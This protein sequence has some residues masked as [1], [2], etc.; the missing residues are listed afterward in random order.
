MRPRFCIVT[1]ALALAPASIEAADAPTVQLALD[2]A[3]DLS[4][5]Y[6]TVIIPANEH[7]FVVIF[8]CGDRQNHHIATKF[9]PID[10]TGP[11]RITTVA[12]A[13]AFPTPDG[14]RFLMRQ[15][16]LTDIPLGRW[17][18]TA[19]V[20]D[21]VVGGVE[22]KVVPP[23][24]ALKLS[25]PI[26]L[27][28]SLSKGTEWTYQFRLLAEPR[29]GLKMKLDEIRNADAQGW[30]ETTLLQRIISLDPE[31]ARREQRRGNGPAESAW[32]AATDRG[33]AVTRQDS[34]D[35][36]QPVDPAQLMVLSPNQQFHRSW[37]W[38][39]KDT[40][41]ELSQKYQMWGPLPL[42]TP[43]GER[44]GYVVLQRI[45]NPDDPTKVATSVE[46]EYAPG[47][48][49]VHEVVVNPIPGADAAARIELDLATM[50]RGSG[51]E[52]EVRPYRDS[53]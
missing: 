49:L 32:L 6:P 47:L 19:E 8:T 50:T 7:D 39:E 22:F 10:A 18:M 27:M 1:A 43:E 20:D 12:R 21:K 37:Q 53:P 25:S 4:P 13:E 41:P 38:H 16:F 33:L 51:P 52:P 14:A 44:S 23:A 35:S 31:G 29:P 30:L 3:A 11:F 28:G 45:P 34:G 9:L 26:E 5:V 2:G 36:P 48:G 24:T 42:Q 40:D 17:T 46:Y 15:P